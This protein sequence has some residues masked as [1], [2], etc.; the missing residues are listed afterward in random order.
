MSAG[1]TRSFAVAGATQALGIALLPKCPLCFALYFGIFGQFLAA[2]PGVLVWAS[3]ASSALCAAALVYR[4]R[5]T[6]R[7][8]PAVAGVLGC[9]FLFLA[10]ILEAPQGWTIAASAVVIGA[11]AWN[12]WPRRS[13]T[14]RFV[15]A[16]CLPSAAATESA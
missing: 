16:C 5:R 1:G 6:R 3:A 7:R 8:I 14:G 4:A 13:A 15:R 11:F 10:R 2:R 12:E 9:G